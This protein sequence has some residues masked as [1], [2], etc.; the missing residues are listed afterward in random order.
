M[1]ESNNLMKKPCSELTI[2]DKIELLPTLMAEIN[3]IVA[4]ELQRPSGISNVAE[5]S[6]SHHQG[7]RQTSC[8]LW[9]QKL[10]RKLRLRSV[11][12]FLLIDV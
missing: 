5:S 8:P 12:D 10:G 7:S 2:E 11:C 1:T 3:K 9:L 4:A 6:L